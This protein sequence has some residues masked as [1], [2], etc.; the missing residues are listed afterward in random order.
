M[1]NWSTGYEII[2]S[3]VR[4]AFWLSHKKIVVT[5]RHHIPK[6]KPIIFAPNHQNAL[7]DPLAIACT[8]P[9]Q[10]VWLARADLFKS[11][12]AQS[13]LKYLKLLPVYR[14]RDGKDNLS[15]NEHIFNQVIH[16]L[17]NK[18]T[19]ALFPEAAHSGKR[20][21]LP[22]KKAI[23]RIALE[24]E[25]KN[26]FSLDL[27]IVPVGIYYNH[28]WKF[29]RSVIV[30][31]GRPIGVDDYK[32]KY[33]ESP[34][35]AMIFLRDEIYERLSPLTIQIDSKSYYQ[36][37][38]NICHLVGKAYSKIRFFNKNSSLQLF[39]TKKELISKIE[40]LESTQPEHF[41]KLI[42]ETAVYFKAVSIEGLSDEQVSKAGEANSL[43]FL[44]RL[45]IAFLSLPLFVFGFVF[46]AIPLFIPRM[47]LRR[48]VKNTPF[49]STFNF[50]TGLIVFPLFYLFAASLI[51]ILTGS[52]VIFVITFILM[53][54]GGKIAYQSLVFYQGLF[55]EAAFLAGKKSYRNTIKRLL[56]QRNE[57]IKF[58]LKE[59]NF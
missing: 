17:E 49:L 3:Y 48:K 22:H 31:Y 10:T 39:Y 45:L 15:N 14:I 38:E 28:Y 29:N 7:M 52:W 56:K 16:I 42:E 25:D 40:H 24:A 26:D 51:F 37:Y 46:N 43:L 13:I 27:Q 41:E 4:F 32:A 59:V 18:Q 57:L 1:K 30:Q 53:P 54:F 21:M 44:T 34:Q 5:G 9:Y 35:K 55:L 20:Q 19:I 36:E 50:V 12:I 2:R 6:G 47:I 23:P 58:I 8:N 33:T 11:K